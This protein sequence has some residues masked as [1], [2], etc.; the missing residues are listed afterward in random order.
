MEAVVKFVLLEGPS[1]P[2]SSIYFKEGA[3]WKHLE[4]LKKMA[5]T[6]CGTLVFKTPILTSLRKIFNSIESINILILYI[7]TGGLAYVKWQYGY[8]LHWRFLRS[9]TPILMEDNDCY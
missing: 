6:Q 2:I 8:W 4:G 3:Y 5:E 9:K 7:R 1:N